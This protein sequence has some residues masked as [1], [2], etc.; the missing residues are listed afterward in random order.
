MLRYVHKLAAPFVCLLF[1]ANQVVTAIY[2]SFFN[3]QNANESCRT[4]SNKL[5]QHNNKLKEANIFCRVQ[6]ILF[7][8]S[9]QTTFSVVM[10]DNPFHIRHHLFKH[11]CIQIYNIQCSLDQK[12]KGL[13]LGSERP[14]LPLFPIHVFRWIVNIKCYNISILTLHVYDKAVINV[15]F[16][17]TKTLGKIAVSWGDV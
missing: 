16:K 8:L 6:R 15:R 17:C 14:D 3:A 7:L 12:N 11:C 10:T 9:W 5:N 13:G 4:Q 1:D 2:S